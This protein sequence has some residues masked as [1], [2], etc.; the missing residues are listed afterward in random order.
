MVAVVTLRKMSNVASLIACLA[1][2]CFSQLPIR[3][4]AWRISP[5]PPA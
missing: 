4:T 1:Q 3:S 5:C 2:I